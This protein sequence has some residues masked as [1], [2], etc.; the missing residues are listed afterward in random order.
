MK[1]KPQSIMFLVMIFFDKVVVNLDI[2]KNPAQNIIECARRNFCG[3]L[4]FKGA[5]KDLHHVAICAMLM[6]VCKSCS[7]LQHLIKHCG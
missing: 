1:K 7:L 3:Q 4:D 5:I 2:K 6:Q